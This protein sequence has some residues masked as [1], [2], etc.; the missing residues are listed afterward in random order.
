MPNIDLKK[1]FKSLSS[2]WLTDRKFQSGDLLP[3]E[4]EIIITVPFFI[5]FFIYLLISGNLQSNFF[6]GVIAIIVVL[7]LI[8]IIKARKLILNRGN[9]YNKIIVR[10][11]AVT[12]IV[13]TCLYLLYRLFIIV[14]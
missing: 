4:W 8:L 14:I 2:W 5:I 3:H 1:I 6:I 12:I 13:L 11:Y 7:L 9:I 10:R